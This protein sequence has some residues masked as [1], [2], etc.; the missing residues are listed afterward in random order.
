M[1]K[2]F[3]R[4]QAAAWLKENDLRDGASIENALTGIAKD[5]VQVALEEE[6][7]DKLGYSRYDWKNKT[8]DNSRNGH[9]KKTVRS[10]FGV[11]DLD[12]PRDVNGEFE[13]GI[14]KKHERSLSSKVEDTILSLFA[15]GSSCRD[16]ES[17]IQDV[18][19]VTVSSEMVSR[20]TDKAL[21]LAREWQ[22]RP[23]D[24]LYPVIYLDGVMFNVRQD[25]VVVKKT[26]YLVFVIDLEG[27]KDVLGIWVGEA[28]SSKFW[29]SVL[30]DLRN[31]GVEDVL[32]ACV[33]GLNGFQE[34][35]NAVYPMAEVQRCIVHQVRNSC[36]FVNYKELKPFCADMRL[37]YTAPNEE[38]GL[39]M[40]ARFEEK[41]AA[42]YL[43]AVRSW[44]TNWPFLA[45]FF[46]YP[47]EIRKLIY[48]TN[49]IENLNRRIRK[50]TKTKGSFPTEDSLFKLLYLIIMDTQEKWTIAV[51]NW[52][53]ILT[54]LTVYFRER[55]EAYL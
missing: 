9:S 46:K 22:N 52:G 3:T 38:A 11:L 17:Q 48:T 55:V 26:A 34:A 19:G 30:S 47:P 41:W 16:I 29:M 2:L 42:K 31:R 1:A 40:L 12:V 15:K 21:P 7:S 6:M 8:V 28:E 14:V 44:K 35:I 23:L 36:K 4:E 20:V 24:K 53:V 5:I 51:P 18:Y 13:P 50:I 27:R 37:V 54:Q 33:D 39:D 43:Y 49:P 10:K 45:T 32:I 25:G